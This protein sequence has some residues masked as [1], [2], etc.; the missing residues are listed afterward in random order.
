MRPDQ[1]KSIITGIQEFQKL[2]P[3]VL[4]HFVFL[5]F[6]NLQK[7]LFS[8][9]CTA[10]HI[11]FFIPPKELRKLHWTITLFFLLL[12]LAP[13][14]STSPTTRQLRNISKQQPRKCPATRLQI[15][16]LLPCVYDVCSCDSFPWTS[17]WSFLI[18]LCV[19][20]FLADQ[21]PLNHYHWWNFH[22]CS[23]AWEI[24][25]NKKNKKQKRKCHRFHCAFAC[26]SICAGACPC[27]CDLCPYGGAGGF[28]GPAAA[29]NQT[30]KTTPMTTMP[31]LPCATLPFS[32]LCPPP[33][34]AENVKYAMVLRK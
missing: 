14:Q 2:T 9:D 21:M 4:G 1:T 23:A 13:S 8:R 6:V 18:C 20:T 24:D 29:L 26:A 32:C 12:Y 5:C 3:V 15:P 11:I 7:N 27:S 10:S 19:Y 25:L 34:R 31:P 28:S 30:M 17:L 16:A 22:P 33:E